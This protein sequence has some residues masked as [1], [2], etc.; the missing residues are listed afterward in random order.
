M[1]TRRQE[2]ARVAAEEEQLA[3]AEAEE[4]QAQSSSRRRAVATE[5]VADVVARVQ[6]AARMRWQSTV[7]GSRQVVAEEEE[8]ELFS[9]E[10]VQDV[11]AR[12]QAAARKRRKH[13]PPLVPAD[14]RSD[15]EL[16]RELFAYLRPRDDRCAAAVTKTIDVPVGPGIGVGDP[17]RFRRTGELKVRQVVVPEGWA[18]GEMLQVTVSCAP[19][20][21]PAHNLSPRRPVVLLNAALASPRRQVTLSDEPLA[22]TAVRRERASDEVKLNPNGVEPNEVQLSY[23]GRLRD[24]CHTQSALADRLTAEGGR[25]CSSN[26]LSLWRNERRERM[27]ESQR[28]AKNRARTPP[29]PRTT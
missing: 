5:P 27:T 7:G 17:I 20:P 11:V 12:V 1:R 22:C 9:T 13:Q 25:N 3:E 24:A 23:L 15:L 28:C 21:P 18:G 6:A 29:S 16:A 8:G 26:T 2:A 10:P 14:P 19:A 4:E